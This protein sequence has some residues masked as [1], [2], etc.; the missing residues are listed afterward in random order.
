MMS[1]RAG[2]SGGTVREISP[3]VDFRVPLGKGHRPR[4]VAIAGRIIPDVRRCRVGIAVHFYWE[5]PVVNAVLALVDNDKSQ[6]R[7]GIANLSQL[8]HNGGSRR[9]LPIGRSKLGPSFLTSA[10]A[11]LIVVRPNV[12]VNPELMSAV[13]TRSRDSF[14]AA[15][16]SPTITM[17]VSP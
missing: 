4:T 8:A 1:G 16:G 17:M 11:K 2:A 14:T 13:I 10:G 12:K 5:I 9:A 7:A 3:L 6:G 15:S